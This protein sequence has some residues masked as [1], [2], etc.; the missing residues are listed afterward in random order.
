MSH[1]EVEIEGKIYSAE[2]VLDEN[3]VTVFAEGGS[4]STQLG[5]MS[6]GAVAKMLLRNLIRIGK[7]TPI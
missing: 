6:E 4:Q 2:Y 5:G 3:V 7:A 1:V